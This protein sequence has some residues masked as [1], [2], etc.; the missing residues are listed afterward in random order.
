MNESIAH[1]IVLRQSLLR[2]LLVLGVVF[3]ALA[4]FANDVYHVLTLPLLHHI[5][6]LGLIATQVPAPFL[7]PLKSALV[8]S[9]FVTMPYFLYQLWRFVA[10]ALYRQ[11]RRL[12]WGFLFSTSFL[13]YIG[14]AFAYFVVMPLVFQ[15][16]LAVAPT[17]VE[18]KP[19]MSQY[20]SFVVHLFLAFG[21]S[22]ELPVLIVLLD[23]TG[24]YRAERLENNRPY[25]IIAS[26][27]VGMLLTPPDV[28]S[29]ILL[30]VPLWMLFELGV[31]FA[32]RRSRLA[33]SLK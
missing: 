3:I 5:K 6:G 11:E 17:G 18:V 14:A 23:M 1:L 31:F 32:K 10:P 28:L 16:L 2:Y 20:F 13:F 9:I 15:F 4:F 29:Q 25:I 26:F 19:D 8:V 22:F 12:L 21:F 7:V 33:S 27:V 24:I 30:A